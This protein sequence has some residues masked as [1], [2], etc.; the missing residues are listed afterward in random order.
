[1]KFLLI[2]HLDEKAWL[3]L[4]ETEQSR[5]MAG[6]MKYTEQLMASGKFIG[7]APLHPTA[8]AATLR[9]RNGQTLK[10]DGPFAETREQVGGYA[11]I[12]ARDREEAI[13][14][15]GGFLGPESPGAIEVRAVAEMQGVPTH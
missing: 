7:G 3:A 13:A 10:T 8:A 5:V 15:A 6:G 14:I 2:T 9:V 1:M 12:E 11:L 4:G